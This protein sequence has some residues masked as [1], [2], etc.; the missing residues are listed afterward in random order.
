MA[1]GPHVD[2]VRPTDVSCLRLSTMHHLGFRLQQLVRIR[3]MANYLAV[4]LLSLAAFFFQTGLL[5]SETRLLGQ[6]QSIN[7]V[8][9]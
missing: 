9:C 1:D 4:F 5:Q 3:V 2:S 8:R 6:D 7:L